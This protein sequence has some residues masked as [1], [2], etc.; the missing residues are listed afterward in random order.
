ML[1]YPIM[2]NIKGER[3][4][5]V[6]G[7]NVALRKAEALAECGA[8][9]EVISPDI[10][11][12]IKEMESNGVVKTVSREYADGD[13]HGAMLAVAATDDAE[14]NNRVAQE[15]RRLGILIN[16]VDVPALSNFIVP[17]CLRRGDLAVTVSTCGKS[18]ALSR[19]IRTDLEEQFDDE[20]AL[21]VSVVEDVRAELIQ[22]GVTVSAEA[23]QQSLK[24]D[25]LLELLRSGQQEEAKSKLLKMLEG[26]ATHD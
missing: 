15:A 14:T 13:L 23:W 10:C 4:V 21:L 7:G 8:S 20:H 12:G 19:K 22:Q 6:G 17:S 9:V 16:V 1:Y 2:L 3:C 11:N 5:V 26:Y 25:Q 18:P 24:L